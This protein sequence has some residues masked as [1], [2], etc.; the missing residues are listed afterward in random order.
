[1]QVVQ[2][3]LAHCEGYH[4]SHEGMCIVSGSSR[5]ASRPHSAIWPVMDALAALRSTPLASQ[6][7]APKVKGR[8]KGKRNVES[9]LSALESIAVSHERAV[10]ML[11][12]RCS[13]VFVWREAAHIEELVQTRQSWRLA[14]KAWRDARPAR[15]GGAGSAGSA[16]EVAAHPLGSQRAIMFALMVEKCSTLA[17]GDAN[18]TPAAAAGRLKLLQTDAVNAAVFRLKARFDQPKALASGYKAWTWELVAADGMHAEVRDALGALTARRCEAVSFH[19]QRSQDGPLIKA[20]VQAWQVSKAGEKE[21]EDADMDG[22]VKR[23]R[24]SEE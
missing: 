21:E 10:H 7:A 8:G 15:G 19:A 3:S 18:S 16:G 1:M 2:A 24:V 14:D 9:R 12:D 4:H 17:T 6:S 20:M 11:T 23:R 5:S 13:W 22:V